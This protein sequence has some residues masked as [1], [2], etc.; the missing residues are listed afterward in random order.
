MEHAI[1]SLVED[2][3][4]ASL[5]RGEITKLSANPIERELRMLDTWIG[6]RKE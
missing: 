1:Y 2:K 6:L 3:K 5:I 4:R